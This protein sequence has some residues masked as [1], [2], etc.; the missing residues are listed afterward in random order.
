MSH[1]YKITEVVGSSPDS[2][3]DAVEQAI[4]RTSETIDHLEWFTVEEIRGHIVDGEVGHYQ[5]SLKLG[6]RLNN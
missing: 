1:V 6:F 3:E 4:A 5:V 2:I